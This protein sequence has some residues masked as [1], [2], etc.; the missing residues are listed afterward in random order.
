M[1][2]VEAVTLLLVHLAPML[3]YCLVSDLDFGRP[4]NQHTANLPL[5][6]MVQL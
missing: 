3:V 1:I 4:V 5:Y 2:L 6:L